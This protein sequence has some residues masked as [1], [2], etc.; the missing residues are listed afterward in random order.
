MQRLAI[1]GSG[2]L[3][4]LIAHH[5]ATDGHYQVVGYFDDYRPAGSAVEG[6]PVLGG[7]EDVEPQHRAGAYDALMIGIGYKHIRVRKAV[8]ERFQAAGVPLGRVI[9][10]SCFVDP[11]VQ[12]GAGVFVLPG[13]VLDRN[14]VLHDNVL[15][16]TAC[17]IA[18]D[19]V[20]RA[21]TFFS[22]RVAVAG[23]TTVGECCNI[24][25]NSTLIDNLTITDFVQTGGGTVV[26][27]PLT[28]PGLYVGSPARF[29]R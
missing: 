2:D 21:H 19:S 3:G 13:C 24:G 6:V 16:N 22:P 20:V 14:V 10:S 29:V 4:Q 27:K 11:S 12:L 1:L 28:A 17:A 5:A 18:H 15:L 26:T 9:H 23:F 7:T 8:F 25:I